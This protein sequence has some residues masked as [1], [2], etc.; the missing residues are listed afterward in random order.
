MIEAHGSTYVRLG[1]RVGFRLGVNVADVRLGVRVGFRLGVNVAVPS[2][3][4]AQEM[5]EKKYSFAQVPQRKWLM[6]ENSFLT[7]G[8]LSKDKI[9]FEN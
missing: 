6:D 5:K 7:C 9:F 4:D 1:V 8:V 3:A 2:S